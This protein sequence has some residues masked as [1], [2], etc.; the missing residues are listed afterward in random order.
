MGGAARA[1]HRCD[2]QRR[3]VPGSARP[4]AGWR[5]HPDYCDVPRVAFTLP[6]IASVG[7]GEAINIFALAIRH[8]PAAEDLKST[9]FAHPTDASAIGYKL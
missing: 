8:G 3:P 4:A 1:P 9:M 2:A 7:V 6:P 5:Q